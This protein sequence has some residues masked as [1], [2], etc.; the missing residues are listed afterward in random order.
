MVHIT[1]LCIVSVC[2][3]MYRVCL[4]LL[5]PRVI[6]RSTITSLTMSCCVCGCVGEWV[7]ANQVVWRRDKLDWCRQRTLIL[8]HCLSSSWSAYFCRSSNFDKQKKAANYIYRAHLG[9]SCRHNTINRYSQVS[10]TYR[11][12]AGWE[13]ASVQL[14][15]VGTGIARWL[16]ERTCFSTSLTVWWNWCAVCIVSS[17]GLLHIKIAVPNNYSSEQICGSSRAIAFR[18]HVLLLST[19]GP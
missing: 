16:S 8:A 14:T 10:V 2:V 1:N 12:K 3:Q 15:G 9:G 6:P 4:H 5:W 19:W 11:I 13:T 7:G 18:I 17:I